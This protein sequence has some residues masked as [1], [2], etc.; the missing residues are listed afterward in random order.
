MDYRLP[1]QD[2]NAEPFMAKSPEYNRKDVLMRTDTVYKCEIINIAELTEL[3]KLFHLKIMN[4][5]E[6][7]LFE[8]RPG[9]FVMLEVPGFGEVPCGAKIIPT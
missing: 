1:K 6:R 8:F 2:I 7:Q 5:A 3:E 9:Q 4:D